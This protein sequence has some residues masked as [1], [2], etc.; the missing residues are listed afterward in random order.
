M[1]VSLLMPGPPPPGGRA[2]A[3]M[4]AAGRSWLRRVPENGP[5]DNAVPDPTDRTGLAGGS[6]PGSPTRRRRPDGDS[7][8]LSTPAPAPPSKRVAPGQKLRRRLGDATCTP[9]G[10]PPDRTPAA[11]GLPRGFR[12]PPPV[13]LLTAKARPGEPD[14]AG[15]APDS[16]KTRRGHIRD[17]RARAGNNCLSRRGKCRPAAAE[18]ATGLVIRHPEQ[19]ER[20]ASET[21]PRPPRPGPGGALAASL[22]RYTLC[23][24][25]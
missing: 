19:R 13:T 1:R 21:R 3:R 8:R 24:V 14:K 25:G 9:G 23:G 16:S 7:I 20:N 11:R 10:R 6:A 5:R 12:G 2:P 22:P 15:R 18:L 4:R 17:G